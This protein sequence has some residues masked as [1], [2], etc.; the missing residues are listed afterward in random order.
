MLYLVQFHL[1]SWLLFFFLLMYKA[2]DHLLLARICCPQLFVC[3]FL[4]S[5]L[6]KEFIVGAL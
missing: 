6:V 4:V 2:H 1:T 3:W 5:L